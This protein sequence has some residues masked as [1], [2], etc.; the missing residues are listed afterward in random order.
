MSFIPNDGRF[1]SR[2]E[3]FGSTLKHLL[4][5]GIRSAFAS[6]CQYRQVQ[7]G[8]R[9][10]GRV[11]ACAVGAWVPDAEYHRNMEGCAYERLIVRRYDYIDPQHAYVPTV[12]MLD[13]QFGKLVWALQEL[14]DSWMPISKPFNLAD[15]DGNGFIQRANKIAMLFNLPLPFVDGGPASIPVFTYDWCP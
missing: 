1:P 13:G 5:Q 9:D 11:L 4:R 15:E 7:S 2:L 8:G 3:F 6:S 10:R 12:I 14:H